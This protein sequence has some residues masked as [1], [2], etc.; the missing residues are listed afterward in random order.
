MVRR[1]KVYLFLKI[2][3]LIVLGLFLAG[4]VFAYKLYKDVYNP[5]IFVKKNETE[6]FLF[7]PSNVSADSVLSIINNQF[8]VR[9]TASLSWVMG[10]KNYANHVYPGRYLIHDKMSNNA[11]INLLRSGN[12]EQVKYTVKFHRTINRAAYKV[13]TE[14]E[15]SFGDLMLLFNDEE[16]LA[17]KG[18]T[19]ETAVA[20]FIPNTYYF[21]WNTSAEEFVDRMK[22][23]FDKFWNNERSRQAQQLGLSPIEVV[24]LASIVERECKWDD[25][26]PRVAGVYLNRLKK[27][28]LLQADPTVVFANQDFKIRRVLKRHLKID[29]PY[30]TYKYKGLPPGPICTPSATT[31]DHVL[32][33]EKHKFIYF[34]AK[35]DFSGYHTFAATHKQHSINA[36]KFQRALNK[37]K[38][39]K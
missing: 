6:A 26:M 10:R 28:M 37:K 36:K 22:N 18:L 34:C 9:D 8:L 3:I 19:K 4:G 16:Y 27:G 14:L 7:I 33:A 24:T 15:A 31:I 12:Q 13:A 11:I 35:E 20:L 2:F 21:N 38:I 17:T 1:L 29:S 32:N 5:N 23:E 30:N 25:E 39:Y